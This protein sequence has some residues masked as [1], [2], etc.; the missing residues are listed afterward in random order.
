MRPVLAGTLHLPHGGGSG[1]S[2]LGYEVHLAELAIFLKRSFPCRDAIKI[3][4]PCYSDTISLDTI[5]FQD[6]LL[7]WQVQLPSL[8]R[9]SYASLL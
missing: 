7:I 5:V 2:C 4:I 9:Y 1:L 6:S 8:G 3:R